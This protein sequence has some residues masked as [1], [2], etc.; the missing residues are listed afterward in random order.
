[1]REMG[2]R[3]V[4]ADIYTRD[5]AEIERRFAAFGTA[6]AEERTARDQAV[7][8]LKAELV[9]EIAEE[10]AAREQAVREVKQAADQQGTNWRQAVYAGV[11]PSALFL[12]GILLQLRGG[13]P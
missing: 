10:S 8:D 9:R 7:R 6:L 5:R 4:S 1:M 13:N 2:L 12:V 11:I 3:V